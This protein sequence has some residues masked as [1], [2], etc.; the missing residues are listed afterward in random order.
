MCLF[1]YLFTYSIYMWHLYCWFSTSTRTGTWLFFL[2]SNIYRV[3]SR[4]LS[5]VPTWSGL[6][7]AH[8]LWDSPLGEKLCRLHCYK[9]YMRWNTECKDLVNSKNIK[10]IP[11]LCRG[12]HFNW[13]IHRDVLRYRWKSLAACFNANRA[14][15]VQWSWQLH[16][17]I[18]HTRTKLVVQ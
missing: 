2:T 12:C 3:M 13:I 7:K 9:I 18:T 14:H 10:C 6:V 16:T 17:S 1:I 8:K 15:Q 5:S 11:C 4:K